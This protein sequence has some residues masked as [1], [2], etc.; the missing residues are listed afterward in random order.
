VDQLVGR[1]RSDGSVSR[2]PDVGASR[3]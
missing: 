3:N 1:G 2:R